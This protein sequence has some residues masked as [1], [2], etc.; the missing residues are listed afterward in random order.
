MELKE[1]THTTVEGLIPS[2]AD[3]GDAR[4]HVGRSPLAPWPAHIVF[5]EV[6]QGTLS[7][8]QHKLPA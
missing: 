5:V 2:P 3:P 8:C 6:F 7:F 4:T 1:G